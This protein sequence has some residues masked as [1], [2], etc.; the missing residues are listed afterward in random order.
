MKRLLILSLLVF[1]IL[2]LVT[3]SFSISLVLG[4]GLKTSPADSQSPR[5]HFSIYLPDTDNS[6]F[7]AIKKGME[8]GA[9]KYHVALSYH[10]IH[11][12]K[13]ELQYASYTG[14][15]GIIVCPYL[16]D[17]FAKAQIEKISNRA[18][19]VVL[20]NHMITPDQPWPYVGPNTFDMGRKVGSRLRTVEGPLIPAIVYSEKSPGIY[21]DRELLEMGLTLAVGNRLSHPVYRLYTTTNPL[22][23][24]RIVYRLS[25]EHPSVNILIFTDGQDTIAATQAL[26]DM[27]LVGKVRIIGFGEEETILDFI[28]KGVIEATIVINPEKIG[29]EAIRSL[30]ELKSGGYTSTSVDTGIEL[31]GGVHK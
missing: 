25:R 27:N 16:D 8:R 14:V 20:I 18:I 31:I 15:D 17:T 9:T 24:E 30:Y 5:Y 1:G 12:G 13:F 4:L 7:N 11:P 2:S 22:D 29:Y 28:Q 21:V 10:S 6:F 23:A 3:L 19:P 26:I